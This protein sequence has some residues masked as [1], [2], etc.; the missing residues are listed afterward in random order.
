MSANAV[1]KK[2]DEKEE[3][4]MNLETAQAEEVAPAENNSEPEVLF[5]LNERMWAVV[6]FE[7]CA[8][9]NLTYNEAFQKM[10]EL[11]A[12]NASGLCIVTDE[13]AERIQKKT[14]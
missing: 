12:Q 2:S 1:S 14:N 4:Q 9:K 6:T 5:D 3:N 10:Q 7:S 13:A 11:K 8:A